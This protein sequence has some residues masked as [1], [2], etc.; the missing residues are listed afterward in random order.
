MIAKMQDATDRNHQQD[1]LS[2]LDAI[3]RRSNECD[4]LLEEGDSAYRGYFA[5]LE[6]AIPACS[7]E[8]GA[9]SLVELKQAAI[10][11]FNQ[12]QRLGAWLLARLIER[13][14]ERR[15]DPRLLP[16]VLRAG[17]SSEL[18]GERVEEVLADSNLHPFAA[19]FFRLFPEFSPAHLLQHLMN[20]TDQ[21]PRRRFYDLIS[22]HGVS[23]F[24]LLLEE[25]EN[26]AE[27]PWYYLRNV[28]SILSEMVRLDD[29]QKGMAIT[30]LARYLSLR[31]RRQIVIASIHAVARLGGRLAEDVLTARLFEPPEQP[32]S[33]ADGIEPLSPAEYAGKL[34]EGLCVINSERA[35]S[36]VMEIALGKATPLVPQPESLQCFALEQLSRLDLNLY[37][38]CRDLL[39]ARIV[40]EITTARFSPKRIFSGRSLRFELTLVNALRQS[41]GVATSAVLQKV[42]SSRAP[43]EI[44][45]AVRRI[46][47]EQKR[48]NEFPVVLFPSDK[49]SG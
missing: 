20:E 13:E 38:V 30:G 22:I 18:T 46:M 10:R 15:A 2:S 34:V 35:V 25:L 39:S 19:P 14:L 28:A 9:A 43:L 12:G 41:P 32:G 29:D 23:I 37:P 26:R 21:A 47:A 6:Q 27:R 16:E 40:Q 31:Q 48:D 44:R 17:S 1:A 7:Q 4:R 5:E 24:P 8:G 11:L 45:E 3:F 33:G 42:L 49:P 36:T